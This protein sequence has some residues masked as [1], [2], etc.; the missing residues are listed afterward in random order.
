MKRSVKLTAMVAIITLC[1]SLC[2]ACTWSEPAGTT[3]TNGQATVTTTTTPSVTTKS[4]NTSHKESAQVMTTTTTKPTTTQSTN[5]AQPTITHKPLLTS[6]ITKKP[7]TTTTK[8][9]TTTTKTT[10]TTTKKSTTTTTTPTL[11]PI[12]DT[13]EGMTY[14]FTL[15]GRVVNWFVE[16]DMVHAIFQKINR[17]ALF[18]TNKGT[19]KTD[20]QLSGRP[21]DF[22][23][24]GNELWIS[25]PDLSCI[26]IHDKTTLK[27]KETLYFDH[28]VSS[29]DVYDN[30]IFY[31]EDDQHVDAYRYDM[32]TRQETNI[33]PNSGYSFYQADV[34]VNT[35]DK[36]VYIS[37][38]GSSS[39]TMFCYDIE[40]LTLQS[41][42][43]KDNYGYS[44]G[45]RTSFLQ[46]DSLY[47]GEFELNAT[48]VSRVTTQYTGIYPSGMLYV[49]ENFVATTCGL[50]IRETGEQILPYDEI[51]QLDAFCITE[52]LNILVI[53]DD[54]L[55]IAV[56]P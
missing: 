41:V 11:P 49:D 5:I 8:T 17:Y 31:T 25:Y 42:Y 2:A 7:T 48:Q 50:Y 38:S 13:E 43:K 53:K 26:K 39:S 47:W 52:S 30:Y 23:C 18:D 16:G 35:K 19:I 34:L 54:M 44:N 9:T 10:T 45:K 28:P 33:L 4:Q 22:H 56:I 29:F 15:N 27:V 14:N 40:S 3:M 24:Y 37:E 21:A 36:L 6:I 20:V 51:G 32:K 1:L 55:S 46:G 12:D